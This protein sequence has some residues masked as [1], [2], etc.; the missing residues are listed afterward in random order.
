MAPPLFL[1]STRSW[2]GFNDCWYSRPFSWSFYFVFCQLVH[3]VILDL[4]DGFLELL[5]HGNNE[6]AGD[7]DSGGKFM[8]CLP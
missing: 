1:G 8:S 2:V 5:A 3:G 6:E 7:L 4:A